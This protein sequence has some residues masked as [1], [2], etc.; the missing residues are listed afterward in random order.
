[1]LITEVNDGNDSTDSFFLKIPRGLH[2]YEA[3]WAFYHSGGYGDIRGSLTVDDK[4]V[5]NP[6]GVGCHYGDLTAQLRVEFR[7]E[8]KVWNWRGFTGTAVVLIYQV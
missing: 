5:I 4:V 7:H 1:M 3:A 2:P 8:V 6:I